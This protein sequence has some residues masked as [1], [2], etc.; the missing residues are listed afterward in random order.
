MTLGFYFFIC[1]F[2]VLGSNYSAHKI[3]SFDLDLFLTV[4]RF[5]YIFTPI[6]TDS[7]I[8]MV[9]GLKIAVNYLVILFSIV[10]F[11][12]YLFNIPYSEEDGQ[13]M[14]YKHFRKILGGKVNLD[15]LAKRLNN[16]QFDLLDEITLKD[17]NK[18]PSSESNILQFNVFTSKNVKEIV[19]SAVLNYTSYGSK[20]S[21]I[22]L[23]DAYIRSPYSI[24]LSKYL[25]I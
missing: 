25:N 6:V 24:S 10:I 18:K 1:F 3:L 22:L 13:W 14:K 16:Y 20:G 4:F 12:L 19:A 21:K 9:V 23:S 8:G 2:I 11:N 5:I 7:D 15:L 17:T